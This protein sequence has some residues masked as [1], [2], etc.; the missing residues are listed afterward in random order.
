MH[1]LLKRQDCTKKSTPGMLYVD[2]VFECYTLEDL[3]RPKKVDGCTAIPAGVYH[4]MINWSNRFKRLLPLLLDV[5]GFTG[6]RIHPGNTDKDTEGCILVGDSPSA[7][8]LGDSRVAF[9][10]LFKKM[11]AE[12]DAGGRITLEIE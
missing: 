1:K 8:F 3:V 2:G 11:K 12:F 10:R 5:P 7:D 6:V 9:D 4:V